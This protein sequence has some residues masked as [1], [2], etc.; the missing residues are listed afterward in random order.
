M[1]ED[2]AQ[3]P[4]NDNDLPSYDD[5]IREDQERR[6]ANET[7]SRPPRP[8]SSS[9]PPERP[10]RR[11]NESSAPAR[12]HST[13]ATARPSSSLPWKY[14]QGFYCRKCGNT[15]YKIKS[16]RSCRSCWRR[17][18]PANPI[19][20]QRTQPTVLQG[21][22]SW[23]SNPSNFA[24]PFAMAPPPQPRTTTTTF[25]SPHRGPMAPMT[26]GPPLIVKPGDPRLGGVLCGECRG[27]GR[28]SFFLDEDL[29]P[30]CR[31]LGRIIR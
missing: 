12:R 20:S 22:S 26:S 11:T 28:V 9:R 27:S 14:P 25:V 3:E 31:G 8:P 21:Q 19:A 7:P 30:L 6:R 2:A 4:P 18:A 5:V 16:G 10:P 24:S 17:F 23:Y 13:S 29:C 1:R 15:G